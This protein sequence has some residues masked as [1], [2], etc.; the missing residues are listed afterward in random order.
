MASNDGA[1]NTLGFGSNG[2]LLNGSGSN[3]DANVV[4]NTNVASA[5]GTQISNGSTI[6]ITNG[7]NGQ[8]ATRPQSV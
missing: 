4:F 8:Q 1:T 6:T 3:A 5:N 7:A 2:P